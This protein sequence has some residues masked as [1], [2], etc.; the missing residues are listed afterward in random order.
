VYLTDTIPALH[1]THRN[2]T[3]ATG[4]VLF[5]LLFAWFPL[6]GASTKDLPQFGLRHF[7]KASGLSSS[8]ILTTV[9]SRKGYLWVG[10]YDGL[11]RFN[12]V[13][14]ESFTSKSHP[15]IPS[16][17]ITALL[18]SRDGVLWAGTL[19]Q[20]VVAFEDPNLKRIHAGS[21]LEGLYVN[22]LLERGN[23]EIWAATRTGLYRFRDGGWQSVGQRGEGKGHSRFVHAI[24]AGAEDSLY[25]AWADRIEWWQGDSCEDLSEH[26]PDDITVDCMAWHADSGLWVGTYQHGLFQLQGSTLKYWGAAEGW[27]S[28]AVADLVFDSRGDLW[29]GGRDGVARIGPEGISWL[30]LRG[31]MVFSVEP[32]ITGGMWVG[33]YLH[34]LYRLGDSVFSTFTPMKRGDV[35]ILGR[36][37]VEWREQILVGT[38]LGFYRIRDGYLEP[39][40]DLVN[41]AEVLIRQAIPSSDGGLWVATHTH[42]LGRVNPDGS[43]RWYGTSEGLGSLTVRAV[44]EDRQGRVW[45]GSSAGLYLLAGGG[46]SKVDALGAQSV[47]TLH[48]LRDGSVFAGMDGEGFALINDLGIRKV[49]PGDGLPSG[50]VFSCWEDDDGVLWLTCNGGGI[51]RYDRGEIRWLS[52]RNGLPAQSLFYLIPDEAGFFWM[53]S[54]TG[55]HR[56]SREQLFRA[57]AGAS[58]SV[59]VSVYDAAEGFSTEGI[60]SVTRALQDRQG[61]LWFPTLDGVSM[62]DPA[63]V[64]SVPDSPWA[65]IE[66][67]RADETLHF[68]EEASSVS[69]GPGT[70]RLTFHFVGFGSDAP[71]KQQYLVK[72]DGYDKD[73]FAMGTSREHAYTNL[74]PG[75]YHFRVRVANRDGILSTRDAGVVVEL[76]ARYYQTPLFQGGMVATAAA[77]LLVGYRLRIRQLRKDQ[78]RLETLVEQRTREWEDAANTA[79]NASESKSRFLAMVSHEVRTPMN[80]IIGLT[81]LLLDTSLDTQQREWLDLVQGSSLKLLHLLNDLLDW[82]KIESGKLTLERVPFELRGLIGECENLMKPQLDRKGLTMSLDIAPEV[83]R[84]LVGDPLRIRQILLNLLSNGI[85]FTNHG[86]LGVVVRCEHLEQQTCNLHFEVNDT[87]VGLSDEAMDRLFR[88]YTQADA[89]ISRTYGG[90]GLGLSICKTLV[91]MM[92]GSIWVISRQDEGATFHF[93]ISLTTI[94]DQDSGVPGP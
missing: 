83:P 41:W 69:I 81:D 54:G 75:R 13:E 67:L 65:V 49:G 44:L 8:T 5:A 1:P 70:R 29:V 10:T 16:D 57:A 88:D 17:A 74:R 80:G 76:K 55:I 7:S 42:G 34:G 63:Q 27:R 31:Q 15:G 33:T 52:S 32:D 18:E 68:P 56:V 45:I 3:Y 89:S 60:T 22:Q 78:R 40:P 46:I 9:Q 62:V 2:H 66:W 93:R 6:A 92:G 51:V 21:R 30:N 58:D 85:K 25:V 77:M 86:G 87:G 12:G 35:A 71:E 50:I 39:F 11:N 38:N 82:S 14:F 94:P 73:W 91:E 64:R 20:G 28:P 90:T 61:R 36:S 37:V 24:A 48:E 47:L 72:L 79:R 4:W 84:R 53:G 19:G 26:F 23:G 59:N 43:S